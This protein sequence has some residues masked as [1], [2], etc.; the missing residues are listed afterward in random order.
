MHTKG[1]R[2]RALFV[3]RSGG[4][5]PN[6]KTTTKTKKRTGKKDEEDDVFDVYVVSSSSKKTLF[7]VVVY[8][9]QN[10]VF[11]RVDD[12]DDDDENDDDDF[13]GLRYNYRVWG[14]AGVVPAFRFRR[15]SRGRE[16]VRT[17]GETRE[18]VSSS[19]VPERKSGESSESD[20]KRKLL[21]A[22]NQV[23]VRA[24][25]GT[26]QE[27]KREEETRI[28]FYERAHRLRRVCQRVGKS[29]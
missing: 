29:E 26:K 11:V 17:G 12:D 27:T 10:G 25:L 19:R 15:H 24:R 13:F 6:L 1:E 2:D 14:P 8:V 16:D 23:V 4:V 18:R 7:C 21:R 5:R 3:E 28:V 9:E 22:T 20:W